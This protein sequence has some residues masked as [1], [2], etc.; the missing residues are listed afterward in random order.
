M[1]PN[2][3][4]PRRS[5]A[6]L[7]TQIDHHVGQM[8][9]ALEEAGKRNN[10]IVVFLSDHGHSTE[11]RNFFGGGYA[12][13]FRGAKF[14]MFEGGI[15]VPCIMAGPTIPR[16]E[17]RDQVGWS[18]DLMPTLCELAQIEHPEDIDGRSLRSVLEGGDVKSPHEW[19]HWQLQD[20]WAVRK[21]P[22]KLIQNPNDTEA[23]KRLEGK[24][25]TWLSNLEL[26]R[27]ERVNFAQEHPDVVAELTA[28][29]GE[30]EKGL[31]N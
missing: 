31:G 23:G 7:V 17:L 11:E 13:E 15:R 8:L 5:Y 20:Q 18:L 27:T 26:D 4:E 12:G 9:S 22:W 28:L 3:E 16:G 14:S 10:T 21:G 29:H 19:L 6:A 2:L 24:D 30:W 1:Y 25:T